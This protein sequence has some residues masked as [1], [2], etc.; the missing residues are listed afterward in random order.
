MS[1]ARVTEYEGGAELVLADVELVSGEEGLVL[2][3]E[4]LLVSGEELV[5]LISCL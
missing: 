2:G 5:A 1:A 3:E 4:G